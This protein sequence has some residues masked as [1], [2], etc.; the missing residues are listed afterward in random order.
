[1]ECIE[2]E[3]LFFMQNGGYFN[4]IGHYQ[5]IKIYKICIEIQ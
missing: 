3:C 2:K 5:M 1:M 4:D